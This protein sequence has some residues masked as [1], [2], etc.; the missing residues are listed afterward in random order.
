MTPTEEE[1]E[2]VKKVTEQLYS[3]Y[4]SGYGVLFGIP[5]ELKSS[6]ELIVEVV[7]KQSRKQFAEENAEAIALYDHLINHPEVK[8]AP[9]KAGEPM[10]K[11][12]NK[13]AKE[14]L[15]EKIQKEAKNVQ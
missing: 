3:A 2:I 1:K 4:G 10:C 12:C 8:N 14:I 11:I 13:T 9:Y 6:V 7:I 15:Q 5:L